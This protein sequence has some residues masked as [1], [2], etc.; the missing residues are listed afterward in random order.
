MT[1]RARVD[2]RAGGWR[3]DWMSKDGVT[4][5]VAVVALPLLDTFG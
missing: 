2:D 5:A 1:K 4:V 3:N